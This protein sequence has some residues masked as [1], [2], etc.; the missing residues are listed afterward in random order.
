[1]KII[2]LFKSI[3]GEGTRAGQVT[4]FIRVAKCNLRCKYCD[5]TYSFTED[6]ATDMTVTEIVDKCKELGAHSITVTGGEPLVNPEIGDLLTALDATGEFDV[7]V[8]T[9][10]TID[11]SAYHHLKRVWFTVDYKCPSSGESDKMNMNAFKTLRNCDVLKF[12]VGS[13]EDLKA[14]Q[15]IISMFGYCQSFS[16]MAANDP[17]VYFSPVFGFEP[18]NIVEFMIEHKLHNCKVQLQLHKYIWPADMRGV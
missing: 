11:P 8:E 1:M 7:N 16:D 15:V 10:G 3:D 13:E 4:T 18:K 9:N 2:E 14:A 17:K 12:V 5:S 6:N